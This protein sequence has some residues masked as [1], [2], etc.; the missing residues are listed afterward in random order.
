MANADPSYPAIPVVHTDGQSAPRSRPDAPI[1]GNLGR[2][3]PFESV[4]AFLVAPA[5]VRP[6]PT[7]VGS[8]GV[9][10]W[11]S[12]AVG[13]EI[14]VAARRTSR[15]GIDPL[16]TATTATVATVRPL[17]S[18]TEAP[19]PKLKRRSCWWLSYGEAR[20]DHDAAGTQKSRPSAGQRGPLLPLPDLRSHGRR[21][22]PG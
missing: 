16:A 19:A 8:A 1:S 13:F 22:R 11:I 10:S 5:G 14:W 17:A 2:C 12:S 6:R 3:P 15:R 21:A 9:G 7:P 20:A 18:E 4:P